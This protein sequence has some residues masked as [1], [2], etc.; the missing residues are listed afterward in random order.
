MELKAFIDEWLNSWSGN[1]PNELLSYYADNTFY[2]DP[3]NP[4]GI[5]K[6]ENINLYFA[7]LLS[8]NPNWIWKAEEIIPTENGCTLKWK[9]EI[10]VGTKSVILFGLDIVEISDWKITRNEVYFDRTPWIEAIQKPNK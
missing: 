9:V 10:P 2:L 8:K 4:A 1:K 6:K 3:A 7:K 5:S